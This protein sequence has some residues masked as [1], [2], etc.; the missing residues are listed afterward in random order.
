VRGV[1][2]GVVLPVMFRWTVRFQ[3]GPAGVYLWMT[4][5]WVGGQA[6]GPE[7][8]P[9]DWRCGSKD[10]VRHDSQVSVAGKREHW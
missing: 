8:D 3:A 9:V 10:T 7:V 4:Y 6:R 2:H 5:S 1:G